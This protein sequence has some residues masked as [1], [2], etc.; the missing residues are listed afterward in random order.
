MLAEP[1]RACQACGL[2]R[3]CRRPVPG[4]GPFDAQVFVIGQSPGATEDDEGKPFVGRAGAVLR[5]ALERNGISSFYLTN[6]VKCHPPGNRKARN[7]ERTACFSWLL[8]ELSLWQPPEDHLIVVLGED[9]SKTLFPDLKFTAARAATNLEFEGHPVKVILHPAALLH[10]M[11]KRAAF[12][13]DIDKVADFLHPGHR[14]DYAANYQVF[15]RTI[16]F[17]EA[18]ER[19]MGAGMIGL[20]AEFFPDLTMIGWSMSWA[21]GEGIWVPR[22]AKHGIVLLDDLMDGRLDLAIHSV[23][24][25]APVICKALGM[26]PYDW[27]WNKVR[28]TAVAAYVMREPNIGLKDLTFKHFGVRMLNFNE[29]GGTPEAF[30][31]LPV[32][33]QARYAVGDADFARRL[34]VEKYRDKVLYGV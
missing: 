25:D 24:A 12:E 27:P 8:A 18:W 19:A 13:Q 1:V 28:D 7:E 34:W 21:S 26:S 6:A 32:E 29:M 17:V 2:H 20:D 33:A 31:A 4:S 9:A 3:T 30:A 5:E 15:G 11:H 22:D 23:Q 10:D 16:G 14:L